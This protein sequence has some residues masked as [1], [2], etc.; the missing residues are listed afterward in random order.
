MNSYSLD[1]ALNFNGLAGVLGGPEANQ[2]VD[3][4]VDLAQVEFGQFATEPIVTASSAATR[5]GDHLQIVDGP[6]AVD[7]GQLSLYLKM[8]PK[9]DATQYSAPAYF[10]YADSQDYALFNLQTQSVD[11]HGQRPLCIEPRLAT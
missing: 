3:Q 8:Y 2:T 1:A 7:G 6:G 9:G 10:W 5:A 11:P 4:I